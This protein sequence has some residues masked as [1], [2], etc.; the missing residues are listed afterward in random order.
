MTPEEQLVTMKVAALYLKGDRKRTWVEFTHE[1][2]DG[3]LV[4]ESTGIFVT[5]VG[6]FFTVELGEIN[7]TPWVHKFLLS[8]GVED[9]LVDNDQKFI[10]FGFGADGPE[11]QRADPKISR[12]TSASLLP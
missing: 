8:R 9:L 5:L 2:L 3:R 7:G 12:V 4:Y 1:L 11:L 6:N 10:R